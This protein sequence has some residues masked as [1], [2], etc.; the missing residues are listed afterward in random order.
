MEINHEGEIVDPLTLEQNTVTK[1]LVQDF[2]N[3]LEVTLL[4]MGQF[5]KENA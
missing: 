5:S 4:K 2:C 3:E 1:K